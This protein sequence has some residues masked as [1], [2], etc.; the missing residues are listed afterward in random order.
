MAT[1]LDVARRFVELARSAEEP[2]V[3]TPMRVHK[4]LY[5]A[6]GW[7]LATLGRPLFDGRIEA[8]KYGPVV[9]ALRTAVRRTAEPVTL[10]QIGGGELSPADRAF[11]DAVWA[12][13][14]EFSASQL[15]RMT[16]AEPPWMQ[17]R[18]RAGAGAG[19]VCSEEI[20]RQ[21]LEAFF[22][23]QAQALLVPGLDPAGGYEGLAQ[24]ERGEGRPAS[25]VF[26]RL[27]ERC[28]TN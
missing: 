6:Q 26:A 22:G 3:L 18:Q 1:T 27:R 15:F 14:G 24:L 20:T 25:E 12:R 10:E 2:D 16:H 17:A 21:D 11:V 28:R 9:P 5:Y 7:A 13:Y 23:P 19:D 8:W 4:L